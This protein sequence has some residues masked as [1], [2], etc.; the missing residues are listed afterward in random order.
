MD[1]RC[2]DCAFEV[3]RSITVCP[4]CR[5]VIRR[6]PRDTTIVTAV[7]AMAIATAVIIVFIGMNWR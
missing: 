1:S 6:W 2:P 5:C 4:R 3:S 7:V